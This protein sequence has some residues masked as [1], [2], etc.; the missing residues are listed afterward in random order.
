MNHKQKV[1]RSLYLL[2]ND[3]VF[4][5]KQSYS[6]DNLSNLKVQIE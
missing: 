1:G 6:K 4:S 2:A 3:Q 5:T